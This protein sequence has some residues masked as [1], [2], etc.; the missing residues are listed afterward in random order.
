M[1]CKRCFRVGLAKWLCI[2]HRGGVQ[3]KMSTWFVQGPY[4]TNSRYIAEE[5]GFLRLFFVLQII[6]NWTKVLLLM[7]KLR[8]WTCG[9]LLSIVRKMQYSPENEINH[10]FLFGYNESC[11]NKFARGNHITFL[12]PN[13]IAATLFDIYWSFSAEKS[14][15][16]FFAKEEV[17]WERYVCLDTSES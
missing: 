15:E 2:V 4:M 13:D 11:N 14:S 6:S 3:N 17:F 9:K 12:F 5:E 16:V 8:V 1:K 10:F 7:I